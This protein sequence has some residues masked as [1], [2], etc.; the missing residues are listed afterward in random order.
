MYVIYQVT[1]FIGLLILSSSFVACHH[2]LSL[3]GSRDSPKQRKT[4]VTWNS[5]IEYLYSGGC[6]HSS[7]SER[8]QGMLKL[9]VSKKQAVLSLK[10][11]YEDYI[12]PG[13]FSK[14]RQRSTTTTKLTL[15]WYGTIKWH[16]NLLELR[17]PKLKRNCKSVYGHAR[18]S[19]SLCKNSQILHLQCRLV[20]RKVFYTD[21]KKKRL[22]KL[23][24][25]TRKGRN[26]SILKTLYPGSSIYLQQ[27]LAQTQLVH[28]NYI[29]DDL[30]VPDQKP[31]LYTK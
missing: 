30:I 1:Q 19:N 28:R 21:R 5:S 4:K 17:F 7:T 24:Q 20:H 12:G 3:K 26:N 14:N 22:L 10:G 29:W 2:N 18:K 23:L 16:K 25:C 27:N 15:H 9:K 11:K 13:L 6:S 8:F 31:I